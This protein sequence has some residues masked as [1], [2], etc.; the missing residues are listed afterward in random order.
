[1]IEVF[2]TFSHIESKKEP[3]MLV[4]LIS[5][6]VLLINL[7]TPT[8]ARADLLLSIDP[9]SLF[10]SA[11][12]TVVFMGTI[13]NT[14]GVTLNA[15]DI[16]LNFSGFDPNVTTP[17]QI[18]GTPDFVLPN[19]SFSAVVDLFSVLIAPTALPGVYPLTVAL[20]DINGNF[21]NNIS[22]NVNLNGSVPVPE[23]SSILLIVFGMAGVYMNYK[24]RLRPGH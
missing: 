16:F 18:L 9:S 7:A 22:V 23:P 6:F 5:L 3:G 20:Q 4:K 21:S 1:V 8:L 19:N 17:E 14:T 2:R 12:A 10:G 24:A 11:G 13:T 15:T